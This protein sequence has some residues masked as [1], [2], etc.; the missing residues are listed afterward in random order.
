MGLEN[1][2]KTSRCY[3]GWF[4]RE[5]ARIAEL[6]AKQGANSLSPP[7][8]RRVNKAVESVE[9]EVLETRLMFERT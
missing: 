2:C 1:G 6:A 7:Q 8:R 3:P 5:L 4:P 9:G